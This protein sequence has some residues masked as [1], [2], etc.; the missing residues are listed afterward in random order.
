MPTDTVAIARAAFTRIQQRFPSL[1]M[2]LDD[3]PAHVE[4]VLDIPRQPGL[5]FDVHLNLQ[6]VDELHIVAGAFWCEWFPCT[7]QD[8]VDD[9]VDAVAGL[10]SGEYRIVESRSGT[11]AVRAV[12]Q[13][14]KGANWETVA[15]WSTSLI[16]W[17]LWIGRKQHVLQNRPAT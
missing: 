13:R 15:T 12:L 2:I 6:N 16:P 11:K 14:P 1:E 10:L 4:L 5:S 3:E 9:Y 8:R 7:K 17:I